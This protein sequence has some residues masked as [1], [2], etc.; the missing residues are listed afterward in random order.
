MI[1]LDFS[2]TEYEKVIVKLVHWKGGLNSY[3]EMLKALLGVD[4]K[5]H[6]NEVIYHNLFCSALAELLKTVECKNQASRKKG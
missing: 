2:N 3:E 5:S 6:G 4:F 1:F